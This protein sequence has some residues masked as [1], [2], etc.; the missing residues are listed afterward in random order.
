MAARK[1]C[2]ARTQAAC[3]IRWCAQS[4]IAE[5]PQEIALVVT[6]ERASL[7][8]TRNFPG[9]PPQAPQEIALVVT[10]ER[11]SLNKT[12][13]FPGTPRAAERGRNHY[14]QR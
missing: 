5:A 2:I 1:K 13:N 4:R 10:G 12:R 3:R 14:A 8:K 11:A 9:T 7:N 6:G